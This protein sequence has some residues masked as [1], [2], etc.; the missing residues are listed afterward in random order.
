MDTI[1]KL[2]E[3]WKQKTSPEREARAILPSIIKKHTKADI[4]RESISFA[5]QTA[6]IKTSSTIK[7]EIF[8]KKE[9]ILTDLIC[10]LGEKAP[11]DIK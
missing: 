5:R 8:I 1:Q 11:R 3:K 4:A 2:L 9:K 6:F 7:T 10:A